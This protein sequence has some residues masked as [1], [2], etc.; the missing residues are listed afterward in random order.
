LHAGLA[1]YFVIVPQVLPDEQFHRTISEFLEEW[2]RTN[3]AL[4]I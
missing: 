4:R 3:S 2:S 1:E